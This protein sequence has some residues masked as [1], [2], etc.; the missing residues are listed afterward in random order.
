MKKTNAMTRGERVI[1]FIEKYCLAPEGDHIGK[2]IRLDPFQIK[3]ILEVYDNPFVT[4]S[5]YLSI[6]R[7]N[8]KTAMIACLLLA[9]ICGPEAVQNSQIVSGAQSKDQA[10]VVFELARK[11]VD[12]SPKLSAVV[13]VQPS[14]KRLIGI[15]KNVL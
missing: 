8:G 10:A 6:A 11:M 15:R 4:H 7:K 12:M 5:A 1:A 13:R 3:F 14:G 9:H 2:P